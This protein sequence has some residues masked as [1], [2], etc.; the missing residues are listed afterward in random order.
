[1]GTE[2]NFLEQ[3]AAAKTLMP[4]SEEVLF[5]NEAHKNGKQIAQ[6]IGKWLGIKTNFEEPETVI[7]PPRGKEKDAEV[8]WKAV[9]DSKSAYYGRFKGN[10]DSI[11]PLDARFLTAKRLRTSRR[12]E[13][14]YTRV[15]DA[16]TLFKLMEKKRD[17]DAVDLLETNRKLREYWD[18]FS[19]V[20]SGPGGFSVGGSSMFDSEYAPIMG[21]P[22]AKQTYLS[23]MLAGNSRSFEAYN[24]SPIV[25]AALMIKHNFVYGRGVKV[26]ATGTSGQEQRQEWWDEFERTT[27]FQNEMNKI[28]LDA[29]IAGEVML[30]Y[31]Q[32]DKP[33]TVTFRSIDPSSVWEIITDPEDIKKVYSYWQ[34]FPTPYFIRTIDNIPVTKYIIR[35][36]PP[37]EIDFLRLNVTSYE[38]RGRPDCYAALTYSKWLRDYLWAKVVRTKVQNTYLWDVTV[39]GNAGDIQTV[40]NT[41]P[42]PQDPGMIFAHNKVVTLQNTNP[43]LGN[44]GRYAASDV[45]IALIGVSMGVPPEFLGGGGA[46]KGTRSGAMLASEPATKHFQDRQEQIGWLIRKMAFRVFSAAE[47]AGLLPKSKDED[48]DVKVIWASITKEDRSAKIADTKTAEEMD[49]ISKRTAAGMIAEE[50]DLDDYDFD[51]EQDTVKEDKEDGVY[52]EG[53]NDQF[54]QGQAAS[55]ALTQVTKTK[56]QDSDIDFGKP[57]G[58]EQKPPSVNKSDKNAKANPFSVNS[59]QIRRQLKN[60]ANGLLK[61]KLTKNETNMMHEVQRQIDFLFE[62]QEKFVPSK[63]KQAL[64]AYHELVLKLMERYST[65]MHDAFQKTKKEIKDAKQLGYGQITNALIKALRR[66]RLL[67]GIYIKAAYMIG[68]ER[69]LQALKQH[70]MIAESEKD[71]DVNFKRQNVTDDSG[72]VYSEYVPNVV[73]G[74]NGPPDEIDLQR[75]D[76]MIAGTEY[77]VGSTRYLSRQKGP[78]LDAQFQKL[79]D[80]MTQNMTQ[81]DLATLAPDDKWPPDELIDDEVDGM[82]SKAQFWGNELWATEEKAAI[83]EWRDWQNENKQEAVYAWA[84]PEDDASCDYCL[85]AMDNSPYNDIEEVPEPAEGDCQCNCRH[86]VVLVGPG[87]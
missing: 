22:W 8:F 2:E 46:G 48:K 41:F 6:A 45:L 63:N 50:F 38:R 57:S 31:F 82:D 53:F 43:T 40:L 69:G 39:D 80:R 27:D 4:P 59:A 28:V 78:F 65:E 7:Q 49:W 11:L 60:S 42:N 34:N 86:A 16:S 19:S 70:G 12:F 84:G 25:H 33:G 61:L 73:N 75:I 83:N 30:R 77:S 17:N 1:V 44:E 87:S 66:I 24:H 18:G 85:D 67:R 3:L 76:E 56:P 35:D 52:G 20:N 71:L 74:E 72:N 81:D 47:A 14:G 10:A 9:E 51:D 26:V 64:N 79:N 15:K 5:T 37:A 55:F 58:D 36:V 13:V 23:D 29:S 54:P 68:R 62:E 21:G 32:G